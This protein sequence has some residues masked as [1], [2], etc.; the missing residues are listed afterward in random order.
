MTCLLLGIVIAFSSCKK[1][2]DHHNLPGDGGGGSQPGP[3]ARN[4][5][6][7][8]NN[9]LSSTKIDSALA[10]WEV[11]GVNQT[12]K[13][14]LVNDRYQMPLASFNNNGSGILTIQLFSQ[15]KVEGKPL[16]WERRQ[17]YTLDRTKE[18][19]WAGP[20]DVNDPLWYPRAIFHYDN[21]MGSRFSA[22]VALRPEDAYLELKGVEPAYAKR[23]EVVRSFHSKET[24]DV[25]FSRG[26]V[27]QHTNLD[28]KGNLVDRQHF[29]NLREQLGERVWNQYRIRASFHL[30]S[31][32]A[33]T[34]EFNLVQDRP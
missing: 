32:P 2:H 12:V 27:G 3:I 18:V 21:S 29:L 19:A 15:L 14:A 16:Q 13:M 17:A 8:L 30:N 31:T 24:G 26:W 28:S 7:T 6:L 33:M 23:I 9:Y 20:V 1:D 25:V 4:L 34:Y 11:N 5:Q 22:L 10:I